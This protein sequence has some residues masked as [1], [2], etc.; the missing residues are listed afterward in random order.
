M[1]LDPQR[2]EMVDDAMVEVL[3]AKTPDEKLAIAEGMWQMAR[4]LIRDMLRQ[5][6]PGWSEAEIDSETAKRMLDESV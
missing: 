1:W 4:D 3:R 5:D 6:H 2:Y